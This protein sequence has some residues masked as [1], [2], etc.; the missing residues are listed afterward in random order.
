[1]K[2]TLFWFG[3]GLPILI[4]TIWLYIIGSK[5]EK[6]E[7]ENYGQNLK[8][9]MIGLLNEQRHDSNSYQLQG[10]K[11]ITESL[12]TS[13]QEVRTQMAEI[14]SGYSNELNGRMDRLLESNVGKLQEINSQ[15]EIRLA[16]GFERTTSTFTDVVKRLALIDEAQKKITSLSSNILNLQEI[17]ADRRARGVFGE[18]QLS[19]LL[20]DTLPRENFALQY[21]L[22]TGKRVDCIL[23][24]P[25]SRG[26]LAIDAKFPLEN[27]QKFTNPDLEGGIRR[28]AQQQFRLD[29]RKHIQDIAEK[30]IIPGETADSA[31]MFIP[32]EAI[33]AE[34]HGSYPELVELSHRMRVWLTSPT[35]LMAVLTTVSAVIKDSIVRGQ[36]HI[37]REH[38]I[39]L[40]RDFERFQERVNDLA[41]HIG[42]AYAN[43]ADISKSAK[44][45]SSRFN[46]IEQLDIKIL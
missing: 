11:V 25:D 19:S 15:V 29:V 43:V 38:L 27:Y 24:L 26:N 39:L 28:L 20:S 21:T 13:M 44:K 4:G 35:T 9:I 12:Q 2:D 33:F 34:I 8:E 18:I 14:L 1:M 17:L 23:F 5:K 40:G 37:V 6:K 31:I 7:F 30:Y 42:Q 10:L 45:I 22:S 41:K 16:R 46:E 3:I 32:A 36:A